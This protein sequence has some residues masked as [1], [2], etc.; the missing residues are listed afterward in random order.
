MMGVDSPTTTHGCVPGFTTVDVAFK[1]GYNS[2]ETL[3]V[4][5]ERWRKRVE[6]AMTALASREPGQVEA[7]AEN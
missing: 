5:M 4:D 3:F 1:Q 7:A 2:V 6:P